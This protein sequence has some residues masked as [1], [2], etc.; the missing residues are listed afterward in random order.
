MD[1][2]GDLQG[3]DV[4]VY[5]TEWCGDSRRAVRFLDEHGISYRSIDIDEDEDAARAVEALN[6]GNR[7]TPTILIDGAHVATEPSRAELAELFGVEL[8]DEP[9]RGPSWLRRRR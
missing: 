6:R 2:A 3:R 8:E 9:G 5:T 4:L 1:D 7:S